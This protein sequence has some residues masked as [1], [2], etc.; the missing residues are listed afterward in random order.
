MTT[1]TW[2]TGG[3]VLRAY[4]AGAL[5]ALEGASIEQHLLVC[6]ECRAAIASLVEAPE[7]ERGWAAIQNTIERPAQPAPIR[8]ARRLGLSEPL[9]VLLAASAS[10]RTAWLASSFVALGFAC[11]AAYV[12]GGQGLWPFLLV[13]PLVPVIGVAAS[14]G[15]ATDP[16]ET[17]LVTSPYGRARLILVRTFAVLAVSL[18]VAFVLGLLLPGPDWVAAA[19]LGPALAL[20]PVLLA[21]A[22]FVGPRVAAGVVAIGWSAFV[23]PSVRVLP[24]TWPVEAS[25]QLMLFALALVAVGVLA[26]RSRLTRQIGAAL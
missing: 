26:A 8:L 2:H 23:L 9:S 16:L 6:A 11:G 5:D 18:P 13:A 21:L 20:I 1:H 17:L 12:S 25:Q 4:L 15:P 10:L 3:D 7:L 24:M 22:A 19:W 14:Y